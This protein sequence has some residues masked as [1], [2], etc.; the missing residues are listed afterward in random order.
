M[1]GIFISYRRND[2]P[3]QVG[4]L[5][6]RL[7]A[8]YGEDFVF[9]DVESI[10]PFQRFESIIRKR[11]Q[12]CDVM[13][14]AIGPEWRAE[15]ATSPDAKDF[16]RLELVEAIAAKRV[17][18]PMLIDRREPLEALGLPEEFQQVLGS[19]AVEIRHSTFDLD[20]DALIRGLEKQGVKPP[21][22]FRRERLETALV[23]A[24]W[25]YSWFGNLSR[26]LTPLGAA[27]VI[28]AVLAAGGWLA[29]SLL[30]RSAYDRGVLAGDAQG[31]NAVEKE[32]SEVTLRY[33]GQIGKERRD[34]LRIAGLVTDGG[35]GVEGARVTVTNT[36]ND[37]KVSDTTDSRGVF[38]VDLEKI[39]IAENDVVRFEVTRPG[40]RTTIQNVRYHDDFREFRVVLRK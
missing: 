3:G 17:L 5:F 16:V 34:S 13:L 1:A 6:G 26:T 11:I 25:P 31:R 20:V 40:Y 10:D 30:Y 22:S 7:A 33:E 12:E 15:R 36:S 18:G 23:A 4:R 32:L 37:E 35:G 19:H 2:V 21:A 14:L 27:A 39:H 28:V 29:G 8:H 38:N 24:G 9:M